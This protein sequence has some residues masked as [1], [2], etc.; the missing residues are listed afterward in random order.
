MMAGRTLSP[1]TAEPI[2]R[3]ERK[4]RTRR[5]LL[6]SA[7]GLLA[8]RGFGSLSLREVTKQAGIVPTAFYRHFASMDELGVALV[9]ESMRTLRDMIRSVRRE[10]RASADLIRVS[11]R[12]LY[13]HVRAHEDHFRFL[14][15]ERY[16]G[17]GAVA[18]AVAIELRL[19]ASEL[20]VDLARFPY[21]RHWSTEDLHMMADLIVTA[22]QATVLELIEARPRDAGTDERIVRT[23]EK[24]LRLILL[25]VPNW[26]SE[27]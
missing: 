19:F 13:E 14:T 21:L 7:L 11:V 8:D 17:T 26:H 18:R 27:T 6:D 9:E 3:H 22:M 15:R 16:G 23:A 24:R 20:A 1:V 4:E 5:A 25:G 12:T 10:P 2:T